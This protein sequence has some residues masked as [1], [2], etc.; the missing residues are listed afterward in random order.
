M[1]EKTTNIVVAGLGG[2]G[3]LK[4]S[5]IVAQA[6]FLAGFDV[7]KS[8][9]HGMSQRGGSVSSDV[10]FGAG[11]YSPMIPPGEAD[12]LVLIAA[13]QFENNRA[14]LR[15]DGMLIAPDAVDAAQLP[16]K[17][18]LNIALLGALSNHAGIPREHWLA[19]IKTGFPEKLRE[20]NLEA[21]DMGRRAG[22]RV[23]A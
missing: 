16:D 13:D 23:P 6:A 12:F 17:R 15:A 18:C 3:V 21:F 7:K 20:I 2:H 14:V 8:E 9:L 1:P 11:V 22:I 10:R 4:A 5:D 19:A